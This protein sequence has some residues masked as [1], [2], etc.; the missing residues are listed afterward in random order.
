MQKQLLSI[1]SVFAILGL[2]SAVP[3]AAPNELERRACAIE[4]PSIIQHVFQGSPDYGFNDPSYVAIGGTDPYRYDVIVQ[5]DNIPTGSFGCQ[6]E[7][8]FPPG[9][10]LY[11]DGASLVDVYAVDR[12]VSPTDTWNNS[13]N[14]TFLFGTI[15][16]ETKPNEVVKRVINSAT[17]S[18]TLTYRFRISSKTTDGHVYFSQQTQDNLKAGLR[19]VHNC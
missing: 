11:E 8:Y 12:K 13:P 14:P 2:S 10:Y 9:A 6:L 3:T 17:C 16:F 4:Y 15:D 19:L 18:S 7:A 1:T 5:F